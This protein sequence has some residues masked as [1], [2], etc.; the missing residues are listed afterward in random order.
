MNNAETVIRYAADS[1]RGLPVDADALAELP[2]TARFT[3]R[4]SLDPAIAALAEAEARLAHARTTKDGGWLF[5]CESSRDR[6]HRVARARLEH[7]L[8]LV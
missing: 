3:I 5:A 6:L 8:E 1:A 4:F 2:A 7:V